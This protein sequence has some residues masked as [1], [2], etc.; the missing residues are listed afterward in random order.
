MVLKKISRQQKSS[1]D[2]TKYCLGQFSRITDKVGQSK[3]PPVLTGGFNR[4]K[5][6]R[7]I[8]QKVVNIGQYEYEWLIEIFKRAFW[9]WIEILGQ[10]LCSIY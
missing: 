8:C 1:L 4:L 5:P 10:I 3:P 2:Y 7:S 6:P 9:W